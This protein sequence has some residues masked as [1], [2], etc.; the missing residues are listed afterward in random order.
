M[1]RLLIENVLTKDDPNWI[2]FQKVPYM[3]IYSFVLFPFTN[4]LRLVINDSI[5]FKEAISKNEF[6][7][8]LSMKSGKKAHYTLILVNV[9]MDGLQKL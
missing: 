7:D 4:E 3:A 5:M 8:I 6:N 9:Y 2:E 1:A